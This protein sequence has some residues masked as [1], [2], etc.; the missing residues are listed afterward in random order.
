M[1]NIFHK[2]PPF[3]TILKRRALSDQLLSLSLNESLLKKTRRKPRQHILTPFLSFQYGNAHQP[4][5]TSSN[6]TNIESNAWQNLTSN[7]SA[8][9]ST[10]DQDDQVDWFSTFKDICNHFMTVLCVCGVIFNALSVIALLTKRFNFK[11]LLRYLFVLLNL[12]DS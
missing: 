1:N 6:V 2:E 11:T 7:R 12:S 10:S 9:N 4:D 3:A 5:M 8:A